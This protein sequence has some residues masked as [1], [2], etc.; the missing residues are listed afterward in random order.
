MS[1]LLIAC[2]LGV[3]LSGCG[4]DDVAATGTVSEVS[5][6]TGSN[7]TPSP[8]TTTTTP[9]TNTNTPLTCGPESSGKKQDGYCYF[10][11]AKLSCVEVCKAKSLKHNDGGTKLIAE[12][13]DKCTDIG[14]KFNESLLGSFNVGCF[15]QLGC[16][17][18]GPSIRRCLGIEDPDA[19]GSFATRI[20]A[21]D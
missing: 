5:K 7:V 20:C 16:H 15:A 10:A 19:V 1:K 17:V 14:H 13:H 8:E 18:V 9:A 6:T 12:K 3:I 21:C 2:L 4:S 11:Q